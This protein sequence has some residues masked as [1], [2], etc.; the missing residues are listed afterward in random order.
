M[1]MN[2]AKQSAEH[3]QSTA[4]D[5]FRVKRVNEWMTDARSRPA[6]KKLLGNLWLEGELYILFA[7]TGKGKSILAVQIGES[8]ASGK[9]IKPFTKSA[10][11]AK[12]ALFRF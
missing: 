9:A 10:G 3:K 2:V 1:I 4:A 11:G 7:D 6:P 5:F 12:G 8:I